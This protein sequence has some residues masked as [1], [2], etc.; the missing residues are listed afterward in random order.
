MEVARPRFDMLAFGLALAL[1]ATATAGFVANR[2]GAAAIMCGMCFAG[3]IAG[4]LVGIS[5]TVLLPV[6]LGLALILWMVWVDQPTSTRATSAIAHAF[7]GVLA[8]WAIA[9]TLRR[10][11]DDW[12][13]VMLLSLSAVVV[14]TG[15]W[16]VAEYVGDRLFDT[17][18]VPKKRDSAED[19]FFGTAGGLFG[20]AFAGLM[21]LVRRGS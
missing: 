10:H 21:A 15:V 16:E 2:N 9:A 4:R 3:L 6:A 8:G 18:L 1:L 13:S 20:I 17:A 19:V 7:G 14:L 12:L 5:G 11:I